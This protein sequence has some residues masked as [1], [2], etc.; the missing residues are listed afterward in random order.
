[1][2]RKVS[3]EEK[4]KWQKPLQKTVDISL[5]K[6]PWVFQNCVTEGMSERFCDDPLVKQL[7]RN[8]IK[9]AKSV[10]PYSK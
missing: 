9:F 5:V 10:H 4:T 8:S 2:R 1:M 3:K 7:N 6:Q